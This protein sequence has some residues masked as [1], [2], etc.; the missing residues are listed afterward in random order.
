MKIQFVIKT[1]CIDNSVHSNKHLSPMAAYHVADTNPFTINVILFVMLCQ[2]CLYYFGNWAE[3]IVQ[4]N[5]L[6]ALFITIEFL[7]GHINIH[8]FFVYTKVH[9]LRN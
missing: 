9:L 4:C 5:V 3:D 7:L 1:V 6:G 2:V 8:E